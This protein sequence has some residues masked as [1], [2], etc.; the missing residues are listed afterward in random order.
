MVPLTVFLSKPV[1]TIVAGTQ[2][3]AQT[4]KFLEPTLLGKPMVALQAT[5][6]GTKKKPPC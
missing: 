6:P 2:N 1:H 4:I 5:L 3:D